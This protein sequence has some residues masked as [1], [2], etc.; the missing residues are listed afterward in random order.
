ML[1]R[2][3]ASIRTTVDHIRLADERGFGTT[4]LV[5]D[6]DHRRR[7]ARGG[8]GSARRASRSASSASRSTSRARTSPRTPARR[9]RPRHG[10]YCWGG[11]PGA[12]EEA[13]EILRAVR[14]GA[15]TRRCRACTS[16]SAPTTGRSTPSPARRSSSS[17]TARPGRAS[18]HGKPV[19]DREPLQ[20]PQHAS[21]RTRAEH[22]DIFAKLATAK[23]QA[24]AATSIRLEGCPVSVAEQVLA[25]VAHRQAQE[26]VPRSE[27]H[28]DVHARY[29]GWK[30][31]VTLNKL[32]RKRYQQNGTFERARSGGA[33]PREA[34]VIGPGSLPRCRA[35]SQRARRTLRLHAQARATVA[36]RTTRAGRTDAMLSIRTRVRRDDAVALVLRSRL[37][38]SFR[39]RRCAPRSARRARMPSL[40]GVLAALARRALAVATV[41]R[42][43]AVRGR[44]PRHDRRDAVAA[45]LPR[46]TSP[47]DT[48]SR[49]RTRAQRSSS[50][51]AS[52]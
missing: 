1:P 42:T 38:P 47:A 17:A 21:I 43:H 15:P 6:R 7:H 51:Y 32:Q 14:Q 24:R 31:R 25:L 19:A 44:R 35:A 37:P 40:V 16:C 36:A 34:A 12:I 26:P 27:Q 46:R 20:G 33:G 48:R 13:I 39:S 5:E 22:E 30:A 3:S 10:D 18:S 50:R 49:V 23:A 4:D 41:A 45:R 29:L 8:A 28:A 9:P 52:A 11:C 2:S